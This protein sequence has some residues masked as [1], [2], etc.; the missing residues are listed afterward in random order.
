MNNF[1]ILLIIKVCVTSDNKKSITCFEIIHWNSDKAARQ[2]HKSFR[3]KEV[4]DKD[5]KAY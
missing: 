4:D 2:Q 1:Q 3:K 5:T